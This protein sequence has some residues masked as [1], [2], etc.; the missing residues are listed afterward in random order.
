VRVALAAALAGAALVLGGES[1]RPE[2]PLTFHAP[3][4]WIDLSP[5]APAANFERVPPEIVAMVRRSRY[6]A[7]AVEPVPAGAAYTQTFNVLVSPRPL[8]VEAD[9]KL[10]QEHLIE[11]LRKGGASAALER[12]ELAEV[13]GVRALKLQLRAAF[14]DVN[15]RVVAWA[16]PAGRRTALLTYSCEEPTCERLLPAFD[17]SARATT[18]ATTPAQF[19]RMTLA[20]NLAQGGAMMLTGIAV[21]LVFAGPGRK[22]LPEETGESA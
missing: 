13:D 15:A 14:A 21:V 16:I 22:R 7:A 19:K 5:G 20:R 4:G 1:F 18:G 10:V 2:R 9:R 11:E 12:G 8:D 17:A 3:A 6:A